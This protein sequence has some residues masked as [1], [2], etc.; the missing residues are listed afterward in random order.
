MRAAGILSLTKAVG[1][2]KQMS[3]VLAVLLIF[4]SLAHAK[5]PG[6]FEIRQSPTTGDF[7]YNMGPAGKIDRKM[8]IAQLI[9]LVGQRVWQGNES[10]PQ[11]SIGVDGDTYI[12]ISTGAFYEKVSGV[13]VLG[14]TFAFAGHAHSGVYQPSSSVLTIYA[15]ISPSSPVQTMLGSSDTA[16]ILSNIGAEPSV[17]EGSLPNSSIISED[18]KNGEVGAEDLSDNLDLSGKV[19]ALPNTVFDFTPSIDNSWQGNKAVVIAGESI[20]IGHIIY[21]KNSTGPRA[22]A[23]NADSTDADNDTYRPR[24]IALTSGTAGNSISIGIGHGVFRHDA[25]TYTDS[26]DEGKPV[27]AGETDGAIT[28]TRP[29]DAGDHII[30]LGNLIDEDE[31]EFHFGSITDVVVNIIP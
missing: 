13:W 4:C 16:S 9:D 27:F 31:I 18:I 15:G 28:L 3:R 8:T 24:G 6:S 25:W 26:Q 7:L 10:P 20:S 29:S 19:V 11:D 5:T 23:Y 22:F 12:N 14:V 2:L 17:T 21:I 1:I 30:H